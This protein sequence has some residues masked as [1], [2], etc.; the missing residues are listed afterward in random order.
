MVFVLFQISHSSCVVI[1]PIAT[2]YEDGRTIPQA[3]SYRSLTE[4]V[5]VR[6]QVSPFGIYKVK[7][8]VHP[9]TGYEGPEM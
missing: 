9:I 2:S 4:D 5:R 1:S 8:K 3:V 6:F 7:V